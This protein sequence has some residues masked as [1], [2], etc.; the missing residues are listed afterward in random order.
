SKHEG[1][2]TSFVIFRNSATEVHA[3]SH[4]LVGAKVSTV[5]F[6][7]FSGGQLWIEDPNGGPDLPDYVARADKTGKVRYGTLVDTREQVYSFDGKDSRTAT[8]DFEMNFV[9]FAFLCEALPWEKDE[10]APQ[11]RETSPLEEG[12][13]TGTSHYL[14]HLSR[15]N[16]LYYDLSFGQR[17][18]GVDK[19][20]EAASMEYY[21]AEPFAYE[22]T[23]EPDLDTTMVQK[24]IEAFDPAIIWV[25]GNRTRDFLE[26]IVDTLY[27]HIDKGRQVA[28]EAPSNDPCWNNRVVKELFER[29]EARCV[30]RAAEPDVVRINDVYHEVDHGLPEVEPPGLVQYMAQHATGSEEGRQEEGSPQGAA[31]ISFEDGKTIASEVK[32]SLRRLHQNLGHPSNLD[33]S[34]HLRL[35]GAD[36]S[37]VEACKRL[38]CQVCQRNRRGSSAKP[39]TLPNLLDFNQ[40]VALDAFYVYDVNKEKVELMMAIDIGTGFVSE[41]YKDIPQRPWRP[42]SAVYG[43]TRLVHL[44][45]WFSI[46]SLAS[47]QD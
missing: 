37:V 47:S 39:A 45:H 26:D 17:I 14:V 23:E 11:K 20:F 8:P 6:G 7:D 5:T 31:A 28:F 19:T 12:R 2:W 22:P 38:R 40:V 15:S 36:P 16:L 13:E 46:L 4:N 42:L 35:A 10:L 1:A 9:S 44:E 30:R 21:V 34:R 24:T 43:A 32:S 25:H 18:G 41:F 27:N 3:D 29:Y 33:L